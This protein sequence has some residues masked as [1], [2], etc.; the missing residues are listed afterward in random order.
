MN[1]AV[2]NLVVSLGAMQGELE[3]ARSANSSCA[4]RVS[5]S[6][7]NT[8]LVAKRLPLDNPEFINYLRIGYVGAQLAALAV[9]YFITLQVRGSARRSSVNDRLTHCHRRSERRT[10]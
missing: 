1:P 10:T 3:L 6:T 5:T 8:L 9:Y 7:A 4:H 2:T